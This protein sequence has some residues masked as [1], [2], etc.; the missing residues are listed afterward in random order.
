MFVTAGSDWK[1]ARA[2]EL[3]GVAEGI[4]YRETPKVSERIMELTDGKGV[5]MVF[6]VVGADVWEDSLLCLKPGGRMV[7]TGTTSGSRSGMNLSVLQGRPPAP[8]GQRR[9]HSPQLRRHDEVRQQ[10]G[11]GRYRQPDLSPGERGGGPPGYG[12]A[13][14][15]WEAGD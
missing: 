7:I 15:L 10:R 11:T 12:V 6:D 5:D 1:L 8:D 13:G 3:L 9:P 4:N 14:V 2:R